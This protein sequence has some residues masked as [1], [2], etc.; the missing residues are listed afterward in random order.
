MVGL[1][2]FHHLTLHNEEAAY[3]STFSTHCDGLGR[4]TTEII[5]VVINGCVI[6]D[7]GS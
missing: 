3:S 6:L 5:V 4:G 1:D 7:Q 2:K